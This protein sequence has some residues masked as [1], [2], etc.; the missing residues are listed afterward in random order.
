[1]ADSTSSMQQEFTLLADLPVGHDL[2]ARS[3]GAVHAQC[4]NKLGKDWRDVDRWAITR[5]SYDMLGDEWTA[6]SE[7]RVRAVESQP[8][9]PAGTA[10]GEAASAAAAPQA[11][12]LRALAWAATCFGELVAS[13]PRERNHRFLEEALE[14]AQAGGATAEEAHLLVDY[15][16]GRPVGDFPQ[17]VGGTVLTLALLCQARGQSMEACGEV[18]L[19]RV[20]D[21][22]PQIREKQ[23]AKKSNS[24]LPVDIAITEAGSAAVG[25][26]QAGPGGVELKASDLNHLR[27]L[28]AWVGCQIG[29]APDELV[30]TVQDLLPALGHEVPDEAKQRLVLAHRQAASVPQYVHAAMKALGKRAGAHCDLEDAEGLG[31][32]EAHPA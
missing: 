19:A 25:K 10:P 15:V 7:F 2:R 8:D 22:L 13:N 5:C 14:L 20:W 31:E 3:L 29:Q 21:K 28:L 6:T 17:E 26:G 23:A 24:P 4:R 30:K 9:D 18:E 12:Q 16:F 27:R 11:Y 32:S 1:M